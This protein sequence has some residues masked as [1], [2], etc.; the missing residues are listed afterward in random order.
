MKQNQVNTCTLKGL[1]DMVEFLKCC[2]V[3]SEYINFDGSY[4]RTI[5]FVVDE[6]IYQILWFNN[7]SK[8]RIGVSKRASFVVFKYIYLDTTFPLISGNKGLGFSF[9]K[10]G[11]KGMFDQE[12]NYYDFRLPL[13]IKEK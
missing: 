9:T 10:K 11:M 7:E 8:L 13:E 1:E 6:Q 3:E 2:G 12:F 5:Q 4:S